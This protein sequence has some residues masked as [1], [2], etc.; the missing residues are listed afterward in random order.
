M[1]LAAVAHLYR[2]QPFV[3]RGMNLR[4]ETYRHENMARL[5]PVS[6]RRRKKSSGVRIALR[7]R[8]ATLLGVRGEIVL[9]KRS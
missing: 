2:V 8:G 7:E 3:N 1:G 9:D 6:V 5:V 4:W